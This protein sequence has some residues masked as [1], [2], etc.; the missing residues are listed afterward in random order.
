MHSRVIAVSF[1][2]VVVI[3]AGHCGGLI[4]DGYFDPDGDF[5]AS[6]GAVVFGPGSSCKDYDASALASTLGQWQVGN[7]HTSIACSADAAPLDGVAFCQAALPAGLSFPILAIPANVPQPFYDTV[8]VDGKCSTT[9]FLNV[10]C[11]GTGNDGDHYCRQFFQQFVAAPG[12][13][14]LASCKPCREVDTNESSP[15]GGEFVCSPDCCPNP[16]TGF[17]VQRADAAPSCNEYPCEP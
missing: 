17:C 14:A 13:I 8:C 5:H 9:A 4:M 6:D 16:A 15:C 3:A 2:V 12:A 10:P 11:P 1:A 7:I